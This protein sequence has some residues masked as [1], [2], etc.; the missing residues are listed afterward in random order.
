M[1]KI[2]SF[3]TLTFCLFALF[4]FVTQQNTNN[5]GE[6]NKNQ[7]TTSG[8][9][10]GGGVFDPNPQFRDRIY[11]NENA[12]NSSDPNASEHRRVI[13]YTSLRHADVSNEKRIWRM[14]DL[15]E[16]INQPLMWPE[17][18][19]QNRINF[20]DLVM[21]GV[22]SEQ[23][24]AF[25]DDEFLVPLTKAEAIE[26]ASYTSIRTE[27]DSTGENSTTTEVRMKLYGRVGKDKASED[28]KKVSRVFLKEDWFFDKQRSVLDV[29]ILG[30]GF[31]WWD[32]IKGMQRPIFWIYY[33]ECRPFFARYEVYNPR[34]DAERRT[35]EDFFWK[36]MFN[37]KI[38]RESNTYERLISIYQSGLD[39]LLEA[40]KIKNDLYKWEHDLWHF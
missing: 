1:K 8:T 24:H 21:E 5:L 14:L 7:A 15:K 3:S 38:I 25:T 20:F 27:Q 11:D 26:K 19:T 40:E 6:L 32:D 16:K 34:N 18:R 13:E 9:T 35:Y 10:T 12:S 4:S 22:E 28:N 33:P 39:A 30:I 36:R 29:R 31:E 2:I 23:I 37:S 17:E